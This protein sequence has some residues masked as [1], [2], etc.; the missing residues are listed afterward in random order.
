VS[1]KAKYTNH[2]F[3][4]EYLK[5]GN[6]VSFDHAR[7]EFFRKIFAMKLAGKTDEEIMEW[8]NEQL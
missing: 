6:R 1:G 5:K 7:K 8:L 3:G 4:K 2:R